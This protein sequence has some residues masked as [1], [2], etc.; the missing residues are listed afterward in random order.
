MCYNLQESIIALV[1]YGF[2]LILYD[3]FIC[4]KILNIFARRSIGIKM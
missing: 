4:F 2:V 3:K 1:H